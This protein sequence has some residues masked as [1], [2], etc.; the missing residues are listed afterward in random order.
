LE[1]LV[2]KAIGCAAEDCSATKANEEAPVSRTMDVDD[3]DQEEIIVFR[4]IRRPAPAVGNLA[5]ERLGGCDNSGV[6]HDPRNMPNEI[7]ESFFPPHSSGV[8]PNLGFVGPIPK[9]LNPALLGGGVQGP[10]LGGGPTSNNAAQGLWGTDSFGPSSAF[11][12][13]TVREELAPPG[14]IDWSSSTGLG[15]HPK[16]GGSEC[17]QHSSPAFLGQERLTERSMV[18]GSRF[19]TK[20][21]FV[22]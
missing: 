2:R 3:E 22:S 11:P 19:V 13:P 1:L 9:G 5:L 4:P 16:V 20:N 14:R 10:A 17:P 7:A 21:P 18:A 15:M 12:R 6:I 8:C